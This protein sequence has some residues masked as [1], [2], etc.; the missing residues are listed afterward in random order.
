MA[1]RSAH[2]PVAGWIVTGSPDQVRRD[3]V[4][5]DKERPKTLEK[6]LSLRS[7]LTLVLGVWNGYFVA[8]LVY[9]LVV[10]SSSS[11]A[12]LRI[13]V[14]LWVLGDVAILGCS[15]AYRAV[16]RAKRTSVGPAVSDTS[17]VARPL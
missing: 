15:W 14:G 13:I 16:T 8:A 10:R 7:V 1:S 5:R 6:W 11:D 2:D 12:A 17:H 3:R 4:R 9:E